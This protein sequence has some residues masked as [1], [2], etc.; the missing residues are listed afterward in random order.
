MQSLPLELC[1]KGFCWKNWITLLLDFCSLL[2]YAA[3]KAKIHQKQPVYNLP[4]FI[5]WDNW[6]ARCSLL[7]QIA[8]S[9][10]L[11]RAGSLTNS[12]FFVSETVD[13]LSLLNPAFT[14][15]H[16]EIQKDFVIF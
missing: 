7:E 5:C 12:A 8:D 3:V 2:G 6:E 4:F 11:A 9:K 15:K 10:G 13:N 1:D 14:Q 16:C